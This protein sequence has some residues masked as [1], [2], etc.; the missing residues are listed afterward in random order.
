MSQ[1]SKPLRAALAVT[2]VLAAGSMVYNGSSAPEPSADPTFPL[3]LVDDD[4]STPTT[5]VAPPVTRDPFTRLD[6]VSVD[7]A[8]EFEST[9]SVLGVDLQGGDVPATTVPPPVSTILD[10]RS[11]AEILESRLPSTTVAVAAP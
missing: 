2:V 10:E 3:P 7:Q 4:D 9:T 6:G 5:W 8:P 11:I 1:V